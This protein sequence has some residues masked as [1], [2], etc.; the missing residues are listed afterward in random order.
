MATDQLALSMPAATVLIAGCGD[1]G[2]EL[3]R[4]L[5]GDGIVTA[6]LRRSG[7]PL[8]HGIATIAAD[9]T[10]PNT[11]QQLAALR[12]QI[13]VYSVAADSGSDDSYRRHYVDGLRNVLAALQGTPL[14]HVF[15][16]S[17][18]RVYGQQAGTVGDETALDETVA[19]MPA[20]FGGRRLL[21]AEALLQ[22]LSCGHTV[23]RLSGIYGPGR[24]RM[25]RLAADPVAWPADNRWTNRIHR[26]DAAAFIAFLSHRVLAGEA[27]QDCSIVSDSEPAPQY[28][29]LQWLAQQLG[30]DSS[31]VVVPPAAGGKRLDN[32]R[33]QQSGFRLAYPDYRTGYSALMRPAHESVSL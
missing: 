30:H 33:M 21:E 31:A 2:C 1:L 12:P 19:A 5:V 28:T 20:D 17:S 10:Q 24:T 14:H 13:L 4:L 11:L 15:F 16:V 32:A 3:G 18:T 8:P 9:V 26:D 25:L 22:D 27:V 7:E 23:L 6:G 29:V